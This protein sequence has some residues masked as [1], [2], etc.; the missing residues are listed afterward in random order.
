M[1]APRLGMIVL[2][3]DET[4]EDEFRQLFATSSATLL[5]S[6]VPSGDELTAD[7]IA[8][9]E[10]NLPASAAL[11]PRG[12]PFDAVAYACTSGTTLIGAERVAK[13]VQSGCRAQAVTDPLTAA[14]H[15]MAHLGCRSIG[16][17]TPYTADI[18]APVAR[19]FSDA[20]VTVR[21]TFSFDEAVEANVARLSADAIRVAAAEVASDGVDALFL[22]CTNLKTLNLIASLEREF[23]CPV[24]SSNLVLAWHMAVL[25]GVPLL[26]PGTL[27]P[28]TGLPPT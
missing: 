10:R 3:A 5:T 21:N 7:S 11:F 9:M 17:V 28:P 18:A 2:Q 6:R 24:L 12:V 4:I 26:L 20:G 16:L 1:N 8:T 14:L 25:T 27:Q 13:L 19:A 22:S 15:A 23:R